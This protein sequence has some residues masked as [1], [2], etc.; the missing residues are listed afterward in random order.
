VYT[1]LFEVKKWLNMESKT[2]KESRSCDDITFL[3]EIITNSRYWQEIFRREYVKFRANFEHI[4]NLPRFN[5]SVI[6]ITAEIYLHP[7]ISTLSLSEILFDP[8]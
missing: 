7:N 5:V 6:S 1:K 3:S 8:P 4:I 2:D